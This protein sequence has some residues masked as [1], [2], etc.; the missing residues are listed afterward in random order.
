MGKRFWVISSFMAT[1]LFA[2][3]CV[4]GST[5]AA[6]NASVGF[7]A[8]VSSDTTLAVE[9]DS[10]TAERVV[11]NLAPNPGTIAFQDSNDVDI[12]VVSNNRT[13]YYLAMSTTSSN[14]TN[15]AD[16]TL[17]ISSLDATNTTGYTTS[18]FPA[19]SWGYSIKTG[20]NYGNYFGIGD[21]VVLQNASTPAQST[22][23]IKFATKVDSTLP[24]GVYTT[25]IL[26]TI[27]AKPSLYMQ[28]VA[29]WKDS[30]RTGESVQAIDNRDM[31]SYW[32]TRIKTDPAI[33]DGR[34]ECTG[35]GSERVC[36]QLWMT[37]NLDLD[38][39]STRT[40]THADTD[41][42][43]TDGDADA[44][45]RPVHSTMNNIQTI[46]D[47]IISEAN[48][49]SA[50][51]EVSY[52]DTVDKFYYYGG[53][54]DYRT[55]ALDECMALL[56]IN[57]NDCY[58]FSA[59]NHYSG[60]TA[61]AINTR[62]GNN[63]HYITETPGMYDAFPNS[64]CP[65]GWK[66]PQGLSSASD[67]SD[68]DYLL[69]YNNVIAAHGNTY[70]IEDN[71]P[72]YQDH[73]GPYV[74]SVGYATHLHDDSNTETDG[75]YNISAYPLWFTHSGFMTLG[76]EATAMTL[77]E[78]AERAGYLT[79]NSF[80]VENAAGL[81]STGET[82]D[83]FGIYHLHTCSDCVAPADIAQYTDLLS[84]RCIAR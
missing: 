58:H 37:Q 17:H 33:P 59:G 11:M 35:T 23:T 54:N 30:V 19:N 20:N 13:G 42:G 75:H 77:Y 6:N 21:Y 3:L 68:F 34:A 46:Y 57:A 72:P 70:V 31:K 50:T 24:S 82:Q 16:D 39:D 71:D 53:G 25:S 66:L 22:S 56:G 8:N 61:A 18:N 69:Y 74:N 7:Y 28:D 55:L 12:T 41:L 45:W 73:Y 62:R 27:I 49:E 78:P 76:P 40:Y 1:S 64:V 51:M 80:Y 60:T 9:I 65:A 44:T 2:I 83:A 32:V 4:A 36:T 52:S 5:Y 47:T 79:G 29:L 84:V 15:T 67:Y 81:H 14:L 43:W 63:V 10:E 48:A 38:L 26:F